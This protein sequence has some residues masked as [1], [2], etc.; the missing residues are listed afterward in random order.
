[1]TVDGTQLRPAVSHEQRFHTVFDHSY[2]FIMLMEP[3][4]VLIEANQ[5]A[6]EFAGVSREEAAGQ[7]LWDMSWWLM[8]TE[9]QEPLRA[10][11][12]RAAAGE[13]VRYETEIQG[14]DGRIIAI[15]F[16]IKSIP[17]AAG[18][19]DMLIAEGR[20]ITE[21]RNTLEHLRRAEH[22][23]EE[24]Q[25]MAHMGHWEYD[26][27]REEAFWSDTLYAV[28]GLEPDGAADPNE[29][30]IARTHPDDLERIRTDLLRAVETLQPYEHHYRLL[31][32]DGTIRLV[33]GA[34]GPITSES[35]QIVRMSGI[36]QDITGRREL[37]ESLARSVARLSTLN[38]MGQAVASSL[39][40][41]WI[42]EQVLSAAR[43]LLQ[44]ELLILFLHHQN[45]LE[46][47]AIDQ[48]DGYDIGHLRIPDN[49]GVA[50][51]VWTMGRA[52][53][54]SGE[55]CR[56][57]R[58][59]QLARATGYEPESIIAVPIRW[60]DQV[61]GVLEAV[62]TR[63][64]A[65]ALDDVQTLQAVATWTAIAIGKVNQHSALERRL[66]ENEAVAAA[67]RT[68]SET[69]EPE[70][71]LELIV[72]TAHQLVP[73]TEWTV[74]HLIRGRPER[75]YPA[76]W[77][78]ISR[79]VDAYILE[80][81]EGIAGQVFLSGLVTNVADVQTDSHASRFAHSV[82]VRSL[83]VAP[84]QSRNRPLGT[85]SVQC[86]E[87]GAF[88]RDDERLLTILAV[89]AGLAMENAQLFDSQRRARGVAELQRERLRELTRQIVTAQ[90]EERLRISRELHDEAGQS[91]TSLK[92]SLDLIRAS[93][94]A[95]QSDLRQRLADVAG[96]ADSTMETL[97]TL[98]HDLRPPGLDAF[99]L[100]V[101]LEGLCH[102]FS[103]RTNLPVDYRGVEL[104]DLPTT[105]S[106]SMYR[107]V[108]EALTNVVKHAEAQH[109][110]VVL[111]HADGHLSLS[112]VDDGHG[113]VFEPDAP[114]VRR[115]GGIGLISMFER[116]ELLG[117][118]LTVETEPERGTR[119]TA[120]IPV[121]L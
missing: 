59:A 109:A 15:D 117:G 69:L 27:L 66:R 41:T 7:K 6:L 13:L 80:S 10:A 8:P 86:G 61:L 49:V 70:N 12:E 97:R 26:V 106:L 5:T 39:E 32:P 53:W 34:G 77:A 95:E 64:D 110:S 119:L 100:N 103:T 74:I 99:G 21:R 92:I 87:P 91:L 81:G 120:R 113:F 85:I 90:E 71:I 101:A 45:E 24:A 28:Y 14:A 112:V 1:M 11:V 17:D 57:R 50:G 54:L 47:A 114:S 33:Y 107:F 2:Q 72:R 22:R 55:E 51:E 42:Y 23:L 78:G 111:K 104:P 60:Q 68:L 44:A 65:F 89:Q 96:L 29:V 38:A 20:D 48:T 116:A 56:N 108:Q 118:T 18:N 31:H 36:I 46:I 9:T 88:T 83:L 52:V 3:D 121:D 30:F 37:E 93:L 98:A 40:L 94:P 76:A 84:I 105:V 19:V 62:H 35:G 73:R 102:D 63:A 43:S 75:L 58:S 79:D 115:Q 25:R 67:S 16:T 4:G 82:G